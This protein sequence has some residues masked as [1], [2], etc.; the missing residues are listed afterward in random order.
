M[1]LFAVIEILNDDD[2]PVK[3]DDEAFEIEQLSWAE[4]DRAEGYV[5]LDSPNYAFPVRIVGTIRGDR[6]DDAQ[7]AIEPI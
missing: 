2:S 7:S 5:H 6:M 3:P 4:G 1:A